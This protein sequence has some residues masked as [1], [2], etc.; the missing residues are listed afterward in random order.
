[1]HESSRVGDCSGLFDPPLG[2]PDEVSGPPNDLLGDVW[3]D[4]KNC[5]RAVALAKEGEDL[6]FGGAIALE[7]PEDVLRRGN[8]ELM[9]D[10]VRS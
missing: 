10:R 6:L 4:V 1:M 5:G 2:G 8:G 7:Q 3:G 9:V